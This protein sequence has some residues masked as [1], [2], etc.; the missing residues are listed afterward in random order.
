M[1]LW[2]FPALQGNVALVTFS[3]VTTNTDHRKPEYTFEKPSLPTD[4]RLCF[5]LHYFL[6][7]D[8][9]LHFFEGTTRQD[10]LHPQIRLA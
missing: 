3:L 5:W 6:A 7:C 1:S 2:L 8:I 4:L 10:Y 9:V